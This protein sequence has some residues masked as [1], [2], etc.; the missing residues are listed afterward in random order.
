MGK[1]TDFDAFTRKGRVALDLM[2][3]GILD[4]AEKNEMGVCI[5]SL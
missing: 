3:H 1:M 4:N 5:F 2:D